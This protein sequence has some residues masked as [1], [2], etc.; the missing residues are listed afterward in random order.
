MG[1]LGGSALTLLGSWITTTAKERADE[2][3]CLQERRFKIED[4]E[5]ERKL[6][7][8]AAWAEEDKYWFS[9][10]LEFYRIQSKI[11]LAGSR[12]EMSDTI[13]DFQSFLDKRRNVC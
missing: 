12:Q 9:R 8:E 2:R 6:A 13:S 4:G 5:R 11:I 7:A 1:A 3:A 10:R